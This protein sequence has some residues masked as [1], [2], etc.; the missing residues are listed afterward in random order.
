[1][2]QYIY[3][4]DRHSA[5]MDE[6]RAV[7]ISTYMYVSL[8]TQTCLNTC[9]YMTGTARVWMKSALLERDADDLDAAVKL[10]SMGVEKYPDFDKLWIMTVQ[11]ECVLLL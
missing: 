11:V 1:M 2:S 9:T 6:E 8:H 10:L 5:G 7:H 3:L 4:H